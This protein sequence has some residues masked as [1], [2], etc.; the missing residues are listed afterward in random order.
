MSV[1]R[2]S[3]LPAVPEGRIPDYCEGSTSMSVIRSWP[4]LMCPLPFSR[5][6]LRDLSAFVGALHP[7]LRR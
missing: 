4:L 2:S 3:W 7:D 5:Q 6:E 1:A